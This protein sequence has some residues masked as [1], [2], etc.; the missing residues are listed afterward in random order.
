MPATTHHVPLGLLN[1]HRKQLPQEGLP[2]DIV[3]GT[4]LQGVRQTCVDTTTNMLMP[5]DVRA[6]GKCK[7]RHRTESR[8]KRSKE[9]CPWNGVLPD[10]RQQ[11]MVVVQ[12]CLH[13]IVQQCPSGPENDPDTNIRH[14]PCC[15]WLNASFGCSGDTKMQDHAMRQTTA[16]PGCNIMLWHCGIMQVTTMHI[17]TQHAKGRRA[18]L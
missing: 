2:T 6:C 17:L 5:I 13:K 18:C 11:P 10:E 3:P 4:I 9:I 14:V 12:V 16:T 8:V 1:R 15:M 7:R